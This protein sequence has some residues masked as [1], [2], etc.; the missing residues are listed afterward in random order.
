LEFNMTSF[1]TDIDL[2]H[3]EPNLMN[4]AA[5]IAQM[6]LSG[7]GNLAGEIFTIGSGSFTA[8]HVTNEHVIVLSGSVAGSF[9]I[10]S[11]DSATRLKLSTIYDEL[12]PDPGD[13]QPAAQP[14]TPSSGSG[15]NFVIRTFWPQRKIVSDQLLQAAGVAIEDVSTITNP[16]ILRRPC[17][18]GTL[19]MIYLALAAASDKPEDLLARAR[20]YEGLYQRSLRNAL[21]EIDRDGDGVVEVHKALGVVTLRRS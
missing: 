8:A 20:M 21:V 18:L 19:G 12:Y 16:Q 6:I 11:V 2:L 13:A 15:L 14:W 1:S 9:P 4:D 7:S 3:W 5:A 10:V 17:A